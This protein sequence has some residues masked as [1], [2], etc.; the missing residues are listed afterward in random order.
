MLTGTEAAL[1]GA[2]VGSAT[3]LVAQGLAHV[4]TVNRDRRSQRRA[5]LYRVVTDAAAALYEPMQSPTDARVLYVLQD[6][7]AAALV[8]LMIHFDHDDALIRSYMD[9]A[10]ECLEDARRWEEHQ[11]RLDRDTPDAMAAFHSLLERRRDAGEAQ[12]RWIK[13]AREAVDA[14]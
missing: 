11:Q 3:S 6:A 9:V 2:G 13:S 7:I 4:L 12:N 1:I 8:K 5:E 14:I 10:N